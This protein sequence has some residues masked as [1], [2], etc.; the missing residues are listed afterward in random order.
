[1]ANLLKKSL[2]LLLALCLCMGLVVV[3][4]FADGSAAPSLGGSSSTSVTGSGTADDPTVTT[5]T[6]NSVNG[7]TV[8][9][10]VESDWTGSTT[11]GGPSTGSTTETSVTGEENVT[12]NTVNSGSGLPV[13]QDGAL[14]GEQTTTTDVTNVTDP[15]P[16]S[17]P[18]P[19]ASVDLNAYGDLSID[20]AVGQT[21]NDLEFDPKQESVDQ[22]NGITKPELGTT[23][24]TLADGSEQT[25]TVTEI[26]EAT[27]NVIGYKTVTETTK[28]TVETKVNNCL[29][30]EPVPSTTTD[31]VTGYTTDVSF[32]PMV[33]A[34]TG[35]TIGYETTTVILDAN[36]NLV[37][38][39]RRSETGTLITTTT[40]TT[41]QTD[42][43]DQT[44]AAGKLTV[45]LSM[46]QVTTGENHGD[47]QMSTITPH[48]GVANTNTTPNTLVSDG[49]NDLVQRG[50]NGTHELDES[51]FTEWEY[52]YL[53][54]FGMESQYLT[55]AM[56][57]NGYTGFQAKQF[58]LIDENGNEHYV[59]CTDF[60]TSPDP[61]AMYSMENVE[62][63]QYFSNKDG[64]PVVGYNS[65]ESAKM[66]RAIALN[67]YFG[68]ADNGSTTDPAVGSLEKVKQLL[69]AKYP[70]L[71]VSG[72][73]PGDA[74][75]ATQAAIWT[76]G[77]SDGSNPIKVDDI[78]WAKRSDSN[79][80]NYDTSVNSTLAQKLYECLIGLDPESV[81]PTTAN[82]VI[83]A[84]D[85]KG[86]TISIT[87][88]C[89]ADGSANA[90]KF[91][92]D[93]GLTVSV[94]PS[95]A[96]GL[97]VSIMQDGMSQATVVRLSDEFNDYTVNDDGT[98]TINLGS[99]ELFEGK[100]VT[101][102][103]NGEQEL[104]NGAYLYSALDE[105]G[106]MVSQTFVSLASGKRT[107]DLSVS[108]NFN[109]EDPVVT[110]TRD[111]HHKTK[112]T[113]TTHNS[114][115]GEWYT[116]YQYPHE[117]SVIDFDP[118][119]FVEDEED[120]DDEQFDEE[121]E[122]FVQDEGTPLVTIP[123]DGVPLGNIPLTGD[124][125]YVWYLL[126]G[127]SLAGLA[128]LSLQEKKRNA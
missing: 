46:S 9:E 49:D 45:D 75:I 97:A 28:T 36:G 114:W 55:N 111:Q 123:D 90:S 104:S 48:A 20:I 107:V 62:D 54:Q 23:S 68:A 33:D 74:V 77:F 32:Q 81:T 6:S 22:L 87:D 57:S 10:E 12:S 65:K 120:E 122:E 71:D 105:N 125:S 88:S 63:A 64:S 109:L 124:S 2:S 21:K 79:A 119:P 84:N 7:N 1:M 61:E 118:V 127:L 102:T 91:K 72:L 37:S 14:E 115:D 112:T 100:D 17:D 47:T 30:A 89:A 16:K 44:F 67:G 93:L 113:T 4:A 83:S 128:L 73:T 53:G 101:I 82:T 78:V 40:T 11:T 66:V 27:G 25:V 43:L 106:K 15:D 56:G 3:P 58:V 60:S 52:Q 51:K 92:A 39:S 86:A 13:L 70:D 103:L 50:P 76:Y 41:V 31:P 24:S 94:M 108:L 80:Y 126:I 18:S 34:A 5:T 116:E 110:Q 95:K 29:P 121:E 19:G 85:I 98:Y 8:T 99:H 96:G 38:A 35:E 69:S 26:T 117:P 42:T 59:Y